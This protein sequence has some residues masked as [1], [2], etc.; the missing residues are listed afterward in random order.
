MS[1]AYSTSTMYKNRIQI[2][3]FFSF[4]FVSE[5]AEGNGRSVVGLVIDFHHTVVEYFQLNC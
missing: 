2:V 1:K 4:E 3:D 5:L